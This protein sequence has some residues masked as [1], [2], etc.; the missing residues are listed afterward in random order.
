MYWVSVLASAAT[1]CTRSTIVISSLCSGRVDHDHRRCQTKMRLMKKQ[2]WYVYTV[3]FT[4]E[5]CHEKTNNVD[6]KQVGHKLSC[7]ST[8]KG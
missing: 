8:E 7:T 5:P 6:S 3:G 4:F 2:T 1:S